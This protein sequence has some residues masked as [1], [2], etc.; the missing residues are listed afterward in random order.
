MFGYLV[1][2]ATL[3][4]PVE[5]ELNGVPGSKERPVPD[6]GPA[7]GS[8]WSSIDLPTAGGVL[9]VGRCPVKLIDAAL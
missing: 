7:L 4:V 3:T 2:T 5:G 6:A 9:S 1:R 8:R